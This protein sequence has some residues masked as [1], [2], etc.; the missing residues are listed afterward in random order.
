MVKPVKPIPDGYH[1]I[2]PNLVVDDARGAIEFYKRAFAA[3]EA[4]PIMRGPDGKVTHAELRIGDSIFML[5]DEMPP[6]PGRPGVYRSP[7]NAGCAT[8][9]LF[10]YVR[11]CDAVFE[12]ARK[13]GCT[14]RQ[15]LENMFWGDRYGTLIDPYGVTWG[16]RP[17]SRTSRRKT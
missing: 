8:S 16:S 9:A 12:R 3:E 14:V 4:F 2:T 17:T 10:L 11:D 1:T 7:K 5:N 15:P 13:A 6:L